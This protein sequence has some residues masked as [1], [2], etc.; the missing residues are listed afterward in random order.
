MIFSFFKSKFICH[1][2]NNMSYHSKLMTLV[3]L[4]NLE[5]HKVIE[6]TFIRS[7]KL[8][9]E[10]GRQGIIDLIVEGRITSF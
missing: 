7:N 10:L 8:Y 4:K 6:H 5:K 9:A 3:P 1:V 2:V